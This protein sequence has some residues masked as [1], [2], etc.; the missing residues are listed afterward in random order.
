MGLMLGSRL[1]TATSQANAVKVGLLDEAS[2]QSD[3]T[4][5]GGGG[6]ECLG[7]RQ[8]SRKKVRGSQA[9][10]RCVHMTK[11]NDTRLLTTVEQIDSAHIVS[12]VHN[13]LFDRAQRR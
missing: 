3:G 12:T 8:S 7:D 4:R 13:Q 6:R 11:R 5:G 1:L 9:V 2:L 10:K